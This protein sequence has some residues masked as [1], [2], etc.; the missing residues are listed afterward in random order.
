MFVA[1]NLSFALVKALFVIAVFVGA[2]KAQEPS[3]WFVGFGGG[4]GK[5]QID[6]KYSSSAKTGGMNVAWNPGTWNNQS[7]SRSSSWG[8]NFEG[9]VGYKHFL[10]DYLG[11]RYYANIAAQFYKDATFSSDK[12]KIGVIDYALNADL[13]LNFYNSPAFSFGIFG[14]FGVGGAYFDSPE[15]SRYESYYGGAKDSTRFTESQFAGIGEVYR[16]HFSAT[17]SVGA[18]VNLFQQISTGQR[19]C[20]AGGDGRRSCR[21]PTSQLEHSLEVGARFFMLPF[22]PTNPAEVVGAICLPGATTPNEYK[23]ANYRYGYEVRVPYRFTL[24]YI[25]AF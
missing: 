12:T 1:K 18:R 7:D 8:F 4:Y 9:L 25:I 20:N 10:N 21:M 2:L 13:L 14:G 3:S 23:C 24:H 5:T 15:I 16:N 19:V 11:F 6:R 17:L 22:K